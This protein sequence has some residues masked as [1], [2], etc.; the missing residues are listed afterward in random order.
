[1]HCV[2]DNN[3]CEL[4]DFDGQFVHNLVLDFSLLLIVKTSVGDNS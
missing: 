1:M 2:H 3:A 4:F